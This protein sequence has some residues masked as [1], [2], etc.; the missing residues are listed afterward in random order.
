M[1][2]SKMSF[3]NYEKHPKKYQYIRYYVQK[4]K[5]KGTKEKVGKRIAFLYKHKRERRE[6]NERRIKIGSVSEKSG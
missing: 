4:K 2:R 5:E 6:T 3:F 1:L